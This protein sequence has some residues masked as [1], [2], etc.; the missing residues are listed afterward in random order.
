MHAIRKTTGFTLI[1]LLVVMAIIA[2]LLSLAAPRYIGNVDKARESVLRQNLATVRDVLD[3]YH[4]DTGQYPASL[5]A[6]IVHHYLR[7]LPLDPMTESNQNWQIVVPEYAEA[8]GVYDIRSS[9]P[10]RARDGSFYRDW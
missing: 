8:G 5:D 3:K 4:A 9:S 2:T 6:L 1:E 7:K 10:D